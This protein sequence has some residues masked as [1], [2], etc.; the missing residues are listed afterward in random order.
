[1]TVAGFGRVH[2]NWKGS[3]NSVN[4]GVDVWGF[5]PVWFEG[6]ARRARSLPANKYWADAEH[7]AKELE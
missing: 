5:M 3:N 7:N 1:M 2:K 4:V 6:V